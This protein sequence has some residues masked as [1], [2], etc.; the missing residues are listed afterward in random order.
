MTTYA[1][2]E[3]ETLVR[4]AAI[5]SGLDPG[6]ADEL[7]AAGLWLA[8][9]S[10]PVCDILGRALTGGPGDELEIVRNGTAAA[11]NL[12]RAAWIG[13]PT[14][15]LL[16]AKAPGFRIELYNLDEPRLLAAIA[17]VTAALHGQ[18]FI[19]EWDDAFLPVGPGSNPAAGSIVSG[20]VRHL[21]VVRAPPAAVNPRRRPGDP[22]STKPARYD[23]A[24]AGDSG[25][26]ALQALARLTYVPASDQSRRSGA[27]AGLTD[28]D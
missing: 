18:R 3:V 27:G 14:F 26:A 21:S 24:A 11:S 5:G 12:A 8:R 10:F 13:P 17:A 16:I 9:R 28:N 25:L 15:D 6:R 23:P 1:L 2:N 20:T 7:A 19:L 4:K 22:I